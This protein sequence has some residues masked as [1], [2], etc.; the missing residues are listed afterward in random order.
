MVFAEFTKTSEIQ[1]RSWC[2][3]GV[4]FLMEEPRRFVIAISKAVRHQRGKSLSVFPRI[5]FW[6]QARLLVGENISIHQK[7]YTGNP[8]G[9]TFQCWMFVSF[10]DSVSLHS[11]RMTKLTNTSSLCGLLTSLSQDKLNISYL[12]QNNLCVSPWRKIIWSHLCLIVALVALN[13][14]WNLNAPQKRQILP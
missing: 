10:V 3:T 7:N 11:M 4:Y 13:A 9:W 12:F 8:E 2:C 5:K 6:C 1:R 14:P